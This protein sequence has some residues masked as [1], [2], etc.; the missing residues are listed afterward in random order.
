VCDVAQINYDPAGHCSD[1][2]VRS[3]I[4]SRICL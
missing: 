2:S 3:G 4:R 1:L